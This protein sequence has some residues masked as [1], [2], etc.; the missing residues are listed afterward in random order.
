[1]GMV[2]LINIISEG[3]RTFVGLKQCVERERERRTI[4]MMGV[5]LSFFHQL[6]MNVCSQNE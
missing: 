5:R 2:S 3:K 1:M 4:K 6:V